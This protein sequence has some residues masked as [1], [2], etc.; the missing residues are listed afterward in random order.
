MKSKNRITFVILF[1]VGANAQLGMW[2]SNC[3][4]TSG[5]G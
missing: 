2:V 3:A 4:V 1:N 5:W